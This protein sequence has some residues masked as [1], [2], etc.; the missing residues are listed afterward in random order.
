MKVRTT[1]FKKLVPHPINPNWKLDKGE[2][3]YNVYGDPHEPG[4]E[5]MPLMLENEKLRNVPLD[6]GG[7][8]HS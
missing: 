5:I 3:S 4:E 6:T 1:E 8:M 2:V 7:R